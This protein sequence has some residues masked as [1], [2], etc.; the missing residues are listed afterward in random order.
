MVVKRFV[1]SSV[2]LFVLALLPLARSA[3]AQALREGTEFLNS[4]SFVDDRLAVETAIAPIDDLRSALAPDLV[5]AWDRFQAAS[6]GEWQGYA[7]QRTGRLEFAEG[8]GI[9]WIPG[10]GNALGVALGGRRTVD[11]V[12]LEGI[13]REFLPRVAPLLG[14]DGRSLV[15]NPGRSGKVS[16]Y[17]WFVD[18]DVLRGGM[19]VEG[20]RV[21]FRVNNGNLVQFGAE[22]LPTPGAAAPAVTVSKERALAIVSNFAGGVSLA[23]VFSDLG[24]LHLLPVG[25]PDGG[26]ADGFAPG[27]GRA[28][29]AV[30]Q[31]VFHRPGVAGTWRGR[32]DAARGEMVEFGDINDYGQ[33]TGGV[34]LTQ[35]SAGETVM[36][37]PFADP[38]ANSAGIFSSGTTSTL[39]GTYVVISDTCGSISQAASGGNIAFGTSSGTDCTTPGHGGAGNTHASRTQFYHLDRIKEKGRGWLPSNSWLNGKLTAAVNLN[40]T[41]NA[42]WDGTRVNFFKSGGGCGNTGELPGVSLH[43]WGHGLDQN[44]G[45]GS[46]SDLGSGETY[47]DFTAAL[48]LHQSCIGPGFLGSN[49]GGYGD[50][51]TS[52]TGV[53][54]ID[55]A[56][57]S[58]NTPATVNGF[59]KARCPTSSNYKGPCGREGHCESYVSSEALWDLANRDLPG[60]GSGAAWSTEDRLWYLSRSTQ[61]KMFNCTASGTWTSNGCFTGSLFRTFRAVDDDDGNLNNGTPH[62]GAIYAALNRHGIACTTDTG[63]STTFAGCSSPSTPTLSLTGG[64]NQVTVSWSNSGS[65]VVYD[66]Y[67]NEL[68]C[69]SGFTKVVNDSSSTSLV[70]TGVANGYTYYYQVVAQPSGNEACGGT[71]TTCQSVTPSGGSCTPPSPPAG[72]SASAAGQTQVNVSWTASSGASSYNVYRATTSGGP[73]T[74]AGSTSST[75]FADTGR[76]CN[77]TYY[78]VV[79]AVG[80]CESGNSAQASATTAACSGCTPATLYGNNFESGSG[81]SDWTRGT[82]G[83]SGG[84]TSWR[85][86][87]SCTAASG[88]HIFRYGG[89]S[90]TADY[91]SNNFNFAQPNGATGIAVPAGSTTT[92]LTFNHRRVFESGYDGGTLTLSLDGSNYYF[93]AASAIIAGASYNGTIAASCPPSGAAGAAVFTGT[94]SSFVSTTVDLDAACDAVTGGSGGCAGQSLRIGFT[95]ITD[96]SVTGDGW[97]LDDVTVTACTP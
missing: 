94:Q 33:V 12:A 24:S 45:S 48:Q 42:Y 16:D 96:C 5:A 60:P 61:T 82:F 71:P 28:L 72:V 70:D 29:M 3:R 4:I 81:L 65:G 74:L 83:G 88:S 62:G 10:R 51:C 27:D 63:A 44:D 95:S 86:I 38:G 80:S 97:F 66:V 9:A 43:E 55:Y 40:Q 19:P 23:D 11:L 25:K 26:F 64:S 68:G 85:G 35:P 30:W 8:S 22:N 50:A 90:C 89:T 31:F 73:Y 6:G 34:Y 91:T 57:H 47:G 53:R 84:N 46:Q 93:V 18:F 17:V 78:Y 15:L 79:T 59:T 52:C 67:R 36:P 13:A 37:M 7:D 32:V 92:R 58:S 21:V 20:A 77:T 39:N 56:K 49:C 54:D 2:V 14:V 76:S 87:Q 69:N 75:S 1:L 41:C